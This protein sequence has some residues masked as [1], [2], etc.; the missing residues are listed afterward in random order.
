MGFASKWMVAVEE[1]VL[2]REFLASAFT[3]VLSVKIPDHLYRYNTSTGFKKANPHN[4]A[5]LLNS[6]RVSIFS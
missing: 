6:H 1:I 3:Y 2:K 4:E 5:C